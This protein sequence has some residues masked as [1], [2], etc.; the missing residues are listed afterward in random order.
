[1]LLLALFTVLV[2][3][4]WVLLQFDTT[5]ATL[6]LQE[7]FPLQDR[8]K[9]VVLGGGGREHAI[10]RALASGKTA[11]II[12]VSPGNSGTA[13]MG[14][15]GGSDRTVVVNVPAVP[16]EDTVHFTQGNQVSLVV[17]G[18]EQPLVEGVANELQGKVFP[19]GVP[20]PHTC[21]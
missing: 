3:T 2:I 18:P 8:V 14:S 17:V 21:L 1:V 10:V 11:L 20:S 19:S 15:S 16:V 4:T 9:V 7:A 6:V 5:C 13:S 12:F